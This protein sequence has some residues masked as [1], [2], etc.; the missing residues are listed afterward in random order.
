MSQE[1]GQDEKA[2][3]STDEQ[4]QNGTADECIGFHVIDE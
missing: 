2:K 3:G 4:A 1:Q